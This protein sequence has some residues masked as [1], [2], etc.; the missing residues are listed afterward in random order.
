MGSKLTELL[1]KLPKQNRKLVI[2]VVCGLVAVGLIAASEF[3]TRKKADDSSEETQSKLDC[4]YERE[5]EARLEDILSS[6]DG[7]GRVNVMVKIS[8][9]EK[10]EFAK[11]SVS[12]SDSDGD[13]KQDS[14]YVV[15][16]GKTNEEGILIGREYPEVQGVIVV[17]QG[18]NNSTVRSVITDAVSSLLGISMNSIS[19]S[20]MK[21]TEE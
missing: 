12:S 4:E 17:C 7:V 3:G 19:V 21:N 18:G 14:Q 10:N 1:G 2:I 15:I 9:S 13:R 11:D 5:L 6:I 16:K 20:K 8:S